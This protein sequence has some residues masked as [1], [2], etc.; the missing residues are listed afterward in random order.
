[1]TNIQ[2]H[3]KLLAFCAAA[4]VLIACGGGSSG[5]TP[6]TF[7]PTPITS[8]PASNGIV[9]GTTGN[10]ANG[11]KGSYNATALQGE[12]LTVSLDTTALTFQYRIDGTAYNLSTSI[13][14]TRYGVLVPVAGSA[15]CWNMRLRGWV[16]GAS[17][18]TGSFTGPVSSSNIGNVCAR[19]DGVL[20][21]NYAET[22]SGVSQTFNAL[23]TPT[24][25]NSA[26]PPTATDLVGTYNI[27]MYSNPTGGIKT[28]YWMEAAVTQTNGVLTARGCVEARYAATCV[29]GLGQRTYRFDPIAGQTDRY[30]LVNTTTTPSVTIG[31]LSVSKINGQVILNGDV[32]NATS[33]GLWMGVPTTTFVYDSIASASHGVWFTGNWQA[34]GAMNTVFRIDIPASNNPLLAPR[35]EVYDSNN[36][37]YDIDPGYLHAFNCTSFNL[38]DCW[39]LNGMIDLREEGPQIERYWKG[40]VV[41]QNVMVFIPATTSSA[42]STPMIFYR[43]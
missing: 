23:L 17:L 13:D 9:G 40:I 2:K 3:L 33:K 16:M 24:G 7:T 10:A 41:G 4:S 31:T 29:G 32:N 43:Q 19:A 20:I 5:T 26:T 28:S 35:E 11:V 34:S 6:E 12:L 22:V 42:L 15:G 21:M 18:G 37:A 1:M 36:I 38:S 39:A 8:T 25:G 30:T 27:L 14:A